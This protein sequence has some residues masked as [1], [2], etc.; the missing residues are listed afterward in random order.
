MRTWIEIS[1]KDTFH[2]LKT[3]RKIISPKSLF[4]A[5]VKSNAY[6][7]N[8]IDFSLLIENSEIDNFAVDSIIEAETLRKKGVKKPILV[9]GYTPPEK[10]KEASIKNISITLPDHLTLKN[11][12]RIKTS[13]QKLKIHLKIDTGMHRQ[14]FFLKEVPQVLKTI[15]KNPSL[16]LEGVYSHFASAK[17]PSLLKETLA[18]V[19]KFEEALKI[20]YSFGFQNTTRHICATS[21]TIILPQSHLD[22]VRIGIGIYGLWPSLET[23]KAFQNK[24]LLKPSLSW[25]TIIGEVKDIPKGSRVGY[26]FTEKVYQKTKLAI[27]PVGYWHGFSRT[28]SGIGEV[29]VHGK[30]AKV[31]GRVSMDMMC[32]DITKIKNAKVGDEVVL[33]G[34]QGKEEITADEIAS[35]LNTTC[36][37]VLTCLNPRIKRVI[38]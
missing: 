24:M 14:G 29:L 2:N 13:S 28:L 4:T 37:E 38:T 5:V 1:K 16:F 23:K 33:I 11:L 25:K 30:R 19:K 8:L 27:I 7:H 26:D 32:V 17:N 36:Y 18:Q 6:G 35:L 10:I 21:G 12:E 34:K 20:L 3:L 31:L 22:M 9:L 15:K